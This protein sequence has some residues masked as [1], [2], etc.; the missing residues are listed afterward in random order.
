MAGLGGLLLLLGLGSLVLPLIGYQ[1]TLLEPLD[2]YQPFAGIIVAVI[3]AVILALP[4]IRGRTTVVESSSPPPTSSTT[5]TTTS[6]ST[7]PPQDQP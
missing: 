3:G 4:A 1:F 2:P 6:T 7:T 5:S